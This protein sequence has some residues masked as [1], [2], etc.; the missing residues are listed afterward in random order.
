MNMNYRSDKTKTI[1]SVAAGLLC[2]VLLLLAVPV[3]AAGSDPGVEH[4]T[5]ACL[6][7][8][9]NRKTIYEYKSHDRC[10]PGS[11]V[12][13][14]AAL[15]AWDEFGRKLDT[16]ITV[17][18]GMLA[19]TSGNSIDFF[20]GEVLTVEQLLNCMLVNS[21][22]DAAVI[23]AVAAAGSTEEFVA[24]MNRKAEALGL[25]GT[26]YTNCTGMHD[27][28]MV[29]T[30][31]D[32]AQVAIACYEIPGFID[33]TSQQKYVLPATNKSPEREIFNR[34]ALISKYY[35]A[36]YYTESAIGMNA[37]ATPQ[38]GYSLA[39]VA[40]DNENDLTYLAVVLGGDEADGA[41]YS[42]VNGRRMFDWAFTAWGYRP[43]L[44]TSQVMCE[45]PVKLSSTAD[46][47]TLAPKETMSVFLPADV[48]LKTAVTYSWHTF[49]DSLDAP[50]EAGTE[51]GT[52]TVVNGSEIVGTCPLVTTVSVQ[53]S[54][55]LYFLNRIEQF[56]MSRFFRATVI[57]AVI[58]AIL[59]VFIT[60]FMR[61]KR[62]RRMSGRR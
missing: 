54:E 46:Y 11:T 57:S 13:L 35:N 21:A 9:E 45:I 29:T 31:A 10:F 40:R 49:E 18:G 52:I 50:I 36:G 7:N 44:Q 59:Y 34:N 28:K 14:M 47:V 20:E 33:I 27:P 38:G 8:F 12:K 56:T 19:E 30:A 3:S 41:V 53:R 16:E 2:L 37:G 6:Y 61:E 26:V 48:D 42:Y 43:V 17:T 1:R 24:R 39:A 4:C 5:S 25:W 62:I 22:N 23:L 60:A 55:F 32:T 15:V 58:L 51:A